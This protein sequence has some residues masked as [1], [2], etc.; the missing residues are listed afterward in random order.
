MRAEFQNQFHSNDT[1]TTTVWRLRSRT[2]L[3]YPFNRNKITTDGAVYAAGDAELFSQ[4]ATAI[5]LRTSEPHA[6]KWISNTIGEIEIERLR[7]S[8]GN[9]DLLMRLVKLLL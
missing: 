5:V 3:S 4:P 2:E 7:E 6:V 1:A 8:R 9:G